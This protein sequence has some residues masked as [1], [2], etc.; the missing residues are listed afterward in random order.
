MTC[1]HCGDVIGSYE[2]LIVVIGAAARETSLT[3]DPT[4]HWDVR[5]E[6][7]HRACY[8]DRVASAEE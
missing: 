8:P 2:P 7:Y 5:G 4:V 1:D 6:R 3:A